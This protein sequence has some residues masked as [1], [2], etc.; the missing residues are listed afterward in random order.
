MIQRSITPLLL[1]ALKDSPIVLLGGARQVG[2]STLVEWLA[3]NGHPAQYVTLDDA[4]VLSAAHNNPEG[5]LAG[6]TEPLIIDEIQRAP[7]IFPALKVSVDKKRKAGQFLLTGS[8][9]VLLIP[10]LSESLAGRMEILSL[11]SFSQSELENATGSFIDALFDGSILKYR[12]KNDR[13]IHLIERMMKGGY[14]EALQRGDPGRRN[15]WFS[16][17]IT[18]ILQRDVRD[19]AHIEGLTALPRLLALLASRSAT[20]L[21]FA[22]LSN[23]IQIPQTTLKRYT[24][25]L[26]ATF[27]IRQVPSWSRNLSKRL[28]KTPKLY[29]TD[30]GLLLYLLGADE[31][32]IKSDGE[33]LGKAAESFVLHEL[34]KLASWSRTQPHIYHFRTQSGLEIDFLLERRDGGII[35]IEVKSGQ[36]VDASSFKTLKLLANETKK[37]FLRGIVL[38]DGNAIIPFEKNLFAVPL[39]ALWA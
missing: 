2:K 39:Q 29:L 17:Y 34:L 35:G 30:T 37:K 4:I 10:K 11:Y 15:A 3:S 38:Y 6:Y 9:N 28:I 16:S 8:A 5:F 12:A 21:N 26:E 25:L 27:L 32:R 36:K 23:S 14:Y 1:D 20:L 33:M 18:T 22:E 19:L 13:Q 31:R 7:E 24:A